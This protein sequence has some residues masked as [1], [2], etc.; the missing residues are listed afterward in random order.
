M[1][2]RIFLILNCSSE[3]PISKRI[4]IRTFGDA[5]PPVS[6]GFRLD[7]NSI[8]V[9]LEWINSSATFWDLL[10]IQTRNGEF[11][12]ADSI[13]NV[14]NRLNSMTTNYYSIFFLSLSICFFND[15]D[16]REHLFFFAASIIRSNYFP[17]SHFLIVFPPETFNFSNQ[18][19]S[20]VWVTAIN[21]YVRVQFTLVLKRFEVIGQLLLSLKE[22]K[23]YLFFSLSKSLNR[24]LTD[25]FHFCLLLPLSLFP[26]S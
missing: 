16:E 24:I 9:K 2:R 13:P 4:S 5:E 21:L 23:I 10:L 22:K 12:N 17:N 3:M 19:F 1:E 6:R 26:S 18:R 7:L 11:S 8:K 15:L 14:L 20:T 25:R